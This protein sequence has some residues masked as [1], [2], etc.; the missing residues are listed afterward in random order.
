MRFSA[1][2]F[3]LGAAAS[4]I[5]SS[6]LCFRNHHDDLADFADCGSRDALSQ[7][8]AELPSGADLAALEG[9]YAAAGCSA[10]D[11]AREAGYALDRCTDLEREGGE[12]RRRMAAMITPAPVLLAARENAQGDDCFSTE[13]SSQKICPGF[14]SGTSLPCTTGPV[15]AKSCRSGWLCTE[16]PNGKDI[17]MTKVDKLDIG[18]IVLAIVFSVIILAG[19]SFLIFMSCA[20]SRAQKKMNARAEATALA[21]AATKKKRNDEVR[22]PLM[23]QQQQQQQQPEYQAQTGGVNPFGDGQ[24]H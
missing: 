15:T 12:L 14:V 13:I 3:A 23:A 10:S 17:C 21:R 18:G 8:F 9:C 7:C 24:P 2:A 11:A 4:A 5:P 19:I 16:D 22:A 20:E 6:D 1:L